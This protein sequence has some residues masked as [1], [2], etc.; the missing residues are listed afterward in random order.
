M[1]KF[2]NRSKWFLSVACAAFLA[3]STLTGCDNSGNSSN[4]V[5]TTQSYNPMT[6]GQRLDLSRTIDIQNRHTDELMA[7][8]GV[9]GTGTGL[10]TDGTPAVYVFTKRANVE[11][12]PS[13]IEGTHTFVVNTGEIQARA[14]AG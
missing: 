14:F 12:I 1:R 2:T 11:G 10:Y 7:I 5:G 9:V 3:V 6:I 4:P 13:S 8:D